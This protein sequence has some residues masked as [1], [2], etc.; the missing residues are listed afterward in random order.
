MIS[1]QALVGQAVSPAKPFSAACYRK[2]I[3]GKLSPTP[4]HLEKGAPL[5]VT[6]IAHL[7]KNSIRPLTRS[8]CLAEAQNPDREDFLSVPSV[9]IRGQFLIGHGWTRIHTDERRSISCATPTSL[10]LVRA[11]PSYARPPKT[12]LFAVQVAVRYSPI[13]S[14]PDIVSPATFP[15]N[16]YDR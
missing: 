16:R 13:S 1:L 2:T 12:C 5:C 14:A 4:L 10:P 15:E 8:Q 9:C 6:E 7:E 11:A 3:S